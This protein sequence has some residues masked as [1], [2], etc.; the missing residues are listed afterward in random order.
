MPIFASPKGGTIIDS[1]DFLGATP[2]D[3]IAWG[4][5]SNLTRKVLLSD[6]AEISSIKGLAV[7]SVNPLQ[8]MQNQ[9]KT[10]VRTN[11]TPTHQLGNT[12][13]KHTQQSISTGGGKFRNNGLLD[14]G[15][16]AVFIH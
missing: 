5:D 10:V 1:A 6:A 7:D 11:P 4:I 15:Y 8:R 2:G 9:G 13:C 12:V 3:Y 14:F 16:A